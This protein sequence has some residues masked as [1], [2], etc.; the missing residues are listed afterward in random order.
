MEPRLYTWGIYCTRCQQ[1]S[2]PAEGYCYWRLNRMT[3]ITTMMTLW[4]H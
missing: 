4:S 1:R 2:C 3:M